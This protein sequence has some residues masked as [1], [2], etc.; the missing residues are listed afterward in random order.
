MAQWTHKATGAA[1]GNASGDA[2]AVS[3][4]A[5][6][7]SGNLL[8]AVLYWE[9]DTNTLTPPAGWSSVH[10]VTC[11]GRFM[12]EMFEKLAGGS[13]PGSYPFTPATNG[14]WR[15]GI[16][17]SFQSGTG[18]GP[19]KDVATGASGLGQA[20]SSQ[21]SPSVTTGGAD[22]LVVV[23]YGNFSGLAPG[24]M[25]NSVTLH[26][27]GPPAIGSKAQAAAGATG[28]T[29]VSGGAVGTEDWAAITA[30]FTS[31]LAGSAPRKVIFGPKP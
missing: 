8:V 11:A 26:G 30:A 24:A 7:V 10:R 18:S 22:R 27:G 1:S 12:L 6:T 13:E 28:Q 25:T 15:E 3:A 2:L 16:I 17:A 21:L 5:G 19:F 4:P 9:S 23:G 29:G 20:L 14:Q 31:D